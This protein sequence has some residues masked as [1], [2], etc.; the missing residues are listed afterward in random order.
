MTGPN[1]FTVYSLLNVRKLVPVPG[2]GKAV[3]FVLIH[4]EDIS[5]CWDGS[6]LHG[7][8]SVSLR[9][10]AQHGDLGIKYT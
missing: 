2:F 4:P 7:E 8:L 1:A 9:L 3:S 6:C 10:V 5:E